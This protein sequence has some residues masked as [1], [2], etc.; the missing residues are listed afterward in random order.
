MRLFPKCQLPVS[1]FY[2]LHG[3]SRMVYPNAAGVAD[4]KTSGGKSHVSPSSN[5]NA[6]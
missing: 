3:H 6:S 4:D 2:I 1:Y 5:R